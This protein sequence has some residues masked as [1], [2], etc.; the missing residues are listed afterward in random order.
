MK[1]FPPKKTPLLP[2]VENTNFKPVSANE[3]IQVPDRA[4]VLEDMLQVAWVEVGRLKARQKA[5]L[6]LNPNEIR[7]LNGLIESVT[8]LAKEQ[9]EADKGFNPDNLTDEEALEQ[10]G[11]AYEALRLKI[12]AKA[13][14]GGDAE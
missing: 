5:G 7:I 3:V 6:T 11:K 9:R 14:E 8:K 2:S 12:E 13:K 1:R 4:V 10:L